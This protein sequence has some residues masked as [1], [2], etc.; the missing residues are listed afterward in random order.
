MNSNQMK[1][2]DNPTSLWNDKCSTQDFY[3][4][5]QNINEAL[6]ITSLNEDLTIKRFEEVNKAALDQLG[7]SRKEFLNLSPLE[8]VDL[9]LLTCLTEEL[10][11][12]L[13]GKLVT[14][15]FT[16]IT[17]TG[18]RVPV[19]ISS[20]I[21]TLSK[22]KKYILSTVQ[23]ITSRK[24]SELLLEKTLKQF[25]SLFKYNPDIIFSLN[26]EGKFINI[27]PAGEKVLNYSINNLA[28]MS[29][30]SL[31]TPRNLGLTQKYFQ[32]VLYGNT[33]SFETTILNKDGQKIEVYITAVPI[34]LQDQIIGVIG[35]AR[36]IT[37]QNYTK[38]CL[39]ESEQ[40]YRALFEHNIDAVLTF[41]L[42]GNFLNVNSATE[43][44]MGYRADDLAGNSFLPFIVPEERERTLAH[45]HTA[46]QG[47]PHQYETSIFN[48]QGERIYLHITL[49]P[50][51][52]E[53]K[54]TGIHCIGKDI[55]EKKEMEKKVSHMAY[56]DL[57]T[58]LPNQHWFQ[59]R[60][61]QAFNKAQTND[62]T[63]SILFLDL[64]RFK[65]INDYL[66]HDM[67]DLLLQKVSTRLT[68][69][70]GNKGTIFRYGGDEFIILLENISEEQTLLLTQSIVDNIPI[71]YDL[72][73]FEAVITVSVGVS[74]YPTHGD[75][76][77]TLIKKADQAMYHAKQQG[78]NNFQL[79]S[80]QIQCITN[81]SLKIETLLHKA[82]E[83]QE[84]TLKYQPQF[85]SKNNTLYGVEALI[86]WNNKELGTIPPEDFIT[87]A[88]ETGLIVPIGEW[89]LRSACKQN[90]E[91][92]RLGLPPL[93]VSV[94]LS[95]LQFYQTDFIKNVASILKE[96]ELDPQYLELEITE[97]ISM[98]AETAASILSELKKIGVKIAID[99][100][101]TGYSSL[102]SLRRFPI[103][104]IKIDQS[105]VKDLNIDDGDRD[106][107]TTIITLGHNL[108]LKVIA[109][110]I[111][112][113]EQINFLKKY[114]CDL[115]QGYY[116][117][118]P[119]DPEKI[120]EII[121]SY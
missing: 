83:R 20:R 37:M 26:P 51:Y 108:N 19:K 68:E 2:D 115:L 56:H 14:T 60:S 64:D 119:I 41:D 85:H 30:V 55:S 100:F 99:D 49:I 105:F 13:N 114:Q 46:I 69:C 98:H 76:I 82:V 1:I 66:G 40:K 90:K 31:I 39:K 10:N 61:I 110:G 22:N 27:N 29:Y 104:H 121:N 71:P 21:I 54:I 75:D 77:K 11:Q 57:L 97:S 35:I 89:V 34:M 3:T 102:N 96:T 87:I 109:V 111:E 12:L 59:N 17:Q 117:S 25:E 9:N 86:R 58:G 95:M 4:I 24:E 116:F 43:K 44:L 18:T 42:K 101:G 107:I 45:F 7:Y 118:K 79:Y 93:V 94:N 5:I 33:V 88:E 106:I 63:V 15:E 84:F 8:I 65:S 53:N 6:Y 120:P 74:L 50:I 16:H 80:N 103:D 72:E 81:G 28:N 23:D 92:Q 48:K 38:K 78:R 36:D 47:Q 70:V 112:T 32:Q 113:K 52:I 67:G 62:G 73:G 91:W